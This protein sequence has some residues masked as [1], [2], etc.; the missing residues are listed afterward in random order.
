MRGHLYE[1]D[2]GIIEQ[3]EKNIGHKKQSLMSYLMR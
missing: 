2:T 3:G 1:N